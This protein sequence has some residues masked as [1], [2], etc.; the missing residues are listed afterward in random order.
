MAIRPG[1]AYRPQCRLA[2]FKQRSAM[3]RLVVSRVI[4][5]GIVWPRLGLLSLPGVFSA[6]AVDSC[7]RLGITRCRSVDGFSEEEPLT[8]NP[9]SVCRSRFDRPIPAS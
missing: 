5:G 6:G 4:A 8:S 7:A 3:A 2:Q 1:V 9:H